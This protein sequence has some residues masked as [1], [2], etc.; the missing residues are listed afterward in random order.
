ML[1]HGYKFSV[2]RFSANKYHALVIGLLISVSC[3][4]DVKTEERSNA[5]RM[6]SKPACAPYCK[7]ISTVLFLF[8]D[9]D[10]VVPDSEK[11][12]LLAGMEN[13]LK[14]KNTKIRIA[15][16]NVEKISHYH[17]PTTTMVTAEINFHRNSCDGKTIDI[18]VNIISP[19]RYYTNQFACSNKDDFSC[20]DEKVGKEVYT[21]I[22]EYLFKPTGGSI[23]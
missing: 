5:N 19:N 13:I 16:L 4:A 20:I 9:K 2:A 3:G 15:S 1:N 14:V 22:E 7:G 8:V 18:N 6:V 12:R 23:L 17:Q 21:I 11:K 10:N